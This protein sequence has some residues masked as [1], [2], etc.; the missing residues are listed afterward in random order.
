MLQYYLFLR[1][2]YSTKEIHPCCNARQPNMN[3]ISVKNVLDTNKFV[4]PFSF[5]FE[6]NL[7]KQHV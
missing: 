6:F 3:R 7:K 1:G 2:I 4:V 5:R